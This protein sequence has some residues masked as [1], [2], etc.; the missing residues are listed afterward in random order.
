VADL[1]KRLRICQD[2][3]TFGSKLFAIRA[4]GYKGALVNRLSLKGIDPINPLESI[5]APIPL[6]D[7][8]I[9]DRY[10]A[11]RLEVN[12]KRDLTDQYEQPRAVG[13]F[14]ALVLSRPAG[15]LP[16]PNSTDGLVTS[17]MC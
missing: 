3:A 13:V 15:P 2:R 11:P 9:K 17:V 8:L 5:P 4:T 16:I 7:V 6:T 12:R 10:W 14:G 1:V